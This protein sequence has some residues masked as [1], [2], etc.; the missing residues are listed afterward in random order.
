MALLSKFREKYRDIITIRNLWKVLISILMT[1]CTVLGTVYTIKSYNLSSR[2]SN[3]SSTN[4]TEP[5]QGQ[6]ADSNNRGKPTGSESPNSA[7]SKVGSRYVREASG[8]DEATIDIKRISDEWSTAGEQ[9]HVK[10]FALHGTDAKYHPRGPNMG[11]IDFVGKIE[12]G[13][14]EYSEKLNGRTYRIELII[15]Q[16]GIEVN[17]DHVPGRF[18]VGV[19]FAGTYR[20][21]GEIQEVVNSVK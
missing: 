7:V 12:N 16:N 8:N 20:K 4:N 11:D 21:Q 18:G 13:R 2:S 19:S 3:Q 17:E 15:S 10:G 1:V 9:I 5:T 6:K 14:I